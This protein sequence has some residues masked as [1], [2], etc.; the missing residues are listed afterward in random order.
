MERTAVSN[1][2]CH[3]GNN[4]Y[5]LYFFT[6]PLSSTEFAGL[7]SSQNFDSRGVRGNKS[8]DEHARFIRESYS[9]NI[10]G[11]IAESPLSPL[12]ESLNEYLTPYGQNA[13]ERE[14]VPVFR[15]QAAAGFHEGLPDL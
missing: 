5:V 9:F 11:V 4:L 13:G 2:L 10:S 8:K 7:M 3:Q 1:C 12:D 14:C 15:V 6:G